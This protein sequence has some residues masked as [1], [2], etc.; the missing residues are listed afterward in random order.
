MLL[1]DLVLIWW[2]KSR[3]VMIRPFTM[4]LQ[5]LGTQPRKKTQKL[6]KHIRKR[7]RTIM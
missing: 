5:D 2:F 7:W 4:V 3:L 6:G 1:L